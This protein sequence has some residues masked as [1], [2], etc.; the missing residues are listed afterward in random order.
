MRLVKPVWKTCSS[1]DPFA[2]DNDKDDDD[3]PDDP[4]DDDDRDNIDDV[5]IPADEPCVAKIERNRSMH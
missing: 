1:E 4:D 3:D 5:D 2:V